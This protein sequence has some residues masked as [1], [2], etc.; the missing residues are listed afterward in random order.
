MIKVFFEYGSCA[1]EVAT[2]KSE[3]LYL[4]CLATLK[5]CARKDKAMITESVED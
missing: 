1:E 3:E 4:A 2:F 5:K